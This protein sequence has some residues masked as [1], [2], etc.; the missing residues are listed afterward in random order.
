ME[1]ERVVFMAL[2]T[3][4]YE[5]VVR[6]YRDLVGVPLEAEDHGD[7]G[8]YSEHSWHEPYFH[9]AIFPIE[10]G[11]EPTRIEL[12]FNSK[13]VRDFHARAVAAGTKVLQEPA[14]MPW[15]LSGVYLD[16]DGN[17]VGVTELP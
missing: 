15:G 12:S 13:N 16:P 10:P 9:F 1:E 7:E 17:I 4:N 6:F 14:Q 3:L 5:S 8:P 11:E 2:R